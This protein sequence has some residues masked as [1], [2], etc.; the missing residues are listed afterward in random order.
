M[1]ILSQ[2]DQKWH[3]TAPDNMTYGV[4]SKFENSEDQVFIPSEEYKEFKFKNSSNTSSKLLNATHLIDEK[5]KLR[6]A[7]MVRKTVDMLK[8][9]TVQKVVLSRVE[10]FTKRSS[11]LEILEALLNEYP[12]ANCYF[13]HHP[14]VGKWMGA[15]PE[16]LAV[17]KGENLQTMSLAGTAVFNPNQD[18]VWGEKE[19]EEQKLVTDFIV[20]NLKAKGV[21]HI[22]K[23]LVQTAQAGTLVHL[24]TDINALIDPSRKEDYIE[25]LHPT[26]AVCGLPRDAAQKF[27]KDNEGYDRSFYTGYLGIV[28]ER[29]ASY[30]VNLRCMQLLDD[31][32]YLYVGGGITAKSDPILEYEETVQ[33]LFTMKSLL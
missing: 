20:E 32:A 8:E 15:T 22:K 14:K 31:E 21:S 23:S 12:A 25:A 28:E 3:K 6:Y 9:S 7:N 30:Y 27:I 26:P 13:F 11:D 4:F 18:H 24:K 10:S 16:I 33:K 5:E 2:R 29:E 17:I 19:I 1:R